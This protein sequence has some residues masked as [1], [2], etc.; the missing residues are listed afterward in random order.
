MS[1]KRDEHLE[2]HF[3][4]YESTSLENRIRI[5]VTKKS[6]ENMIRFY[7]YV[8]ENFVPIYCKEQKHPNCFHRF[9]KS[10]KLQNEID[11]DSILD[12]FLEMEHQRA[13]EYDKEIKGT[14]LIS[15]KKHNWTGE[16]FEKCPNC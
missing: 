2:F 14:P 11:I 5:N 15:C 8:E 12:E 6:F 7:Y 13:I 10:E 4:K 16:H 9:V 3:G 1:K